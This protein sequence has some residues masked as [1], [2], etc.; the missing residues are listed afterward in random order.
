M[1]LAGDVFDQIDAAGTDLDLL[2][3]RNLELAV[4]AQRDLVLAPRRRMPVGDASGRGAAKLGAGVRQQLI[5]VDS[6]ARSEFGLDL[7]RICQ[8]VR[9]RVEPVDHEG[10]A[11]R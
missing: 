3:A 1:A 8:A 2:A 10:L 9:T 11:L 6:A 4:A 7:L 5:A